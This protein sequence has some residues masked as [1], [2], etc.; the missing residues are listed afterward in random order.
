MA[1]PIINWEDPPTEVLKQAADGPRATIIDLLFLLGNL[2]V[3]HWR[4][5]T[6]TNEHAALGQ[7]YDSLSDLVDTLAETL[8]GDEGSREMPSRKA[9][10][11]QGDGY[12]GL[13]SEG[14]RLADSLCTALADKPDLANITADIRQAMNKAAYLLS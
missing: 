2:R 4:A 1:N 5:S 8:M 10:I 9:T 14:K 7:L 11:G 6:K 13:I 12:D 3:A